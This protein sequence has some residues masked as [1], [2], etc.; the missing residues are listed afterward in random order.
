M[1]LN[2]ID[3]TGIHIGSV[4]DFLAQLLGGGDGYPGFLQIYGADINVQPNSPDGQMLN[5]F[6]QAEA[7]ISELAVQ[8]Y[9]SFDPDQAYGASLDR[10][11]AYNGVIR[12]GGTFTQ[13]AVAVTTS[14][15]LTLPGLDTNPA[16]G[17]FTVQD[18]A[19]NQYSLLTTFAF[20]GA[21][22]IDL[23]F[24]AVKMG[25]VTSAS[26]TVTVIT[27]PQLG[28][29]SVN[30]PAP[31]TTVGT[32]QE[33]DSAL[34]IRRSNSV[35]NPSQGFD[36]GLR[37]GLLDIVGVTF[38]KVYQNR[39]DT[40]D[41]NGIP[42]HLIWVVVAA[43]SGD[44][45]AI[46]Q[47]IYVHLNAGPG[48]KNAGTGGAGTVTLSG[49]TIGSIAVAAGGTGYNNAPTVKIVGNGTGAT[50]H[51]VVTAGVI[52]SF[53]VDTPGTGYTGT[54]TVVLNPNTNLVEILQLDGNNDPIYF[55]N[56][57]LQPLW[58]EATVVAITGSVD[59][60]FISAQVLEEF[61]SKYDIGQAADTASIVAFIKAIAPNASVSAEGVSTDGSS[62]SSLVTPTGVNYQ[63]EIP[64]S[65]HISIT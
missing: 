4:D 31:P 15:A 35:A 13:L 25:P 36:Q 44:N 63:F 19:G 18:G 39:G 23:I 16:G 55:D 12:Q 54:P 58:F 14:Q 10:D 57:I 33:T 45:A 27:T 60:A 40:T 34:R 50:A 65:G 42:P 51:A 3:A 21:A 9:D 5:I 41:A 22:T 1:P 29:T 56:P 47:V 59:L 53:V 2:Y 43:P 17:A 32:N 20:I 37:G 26:N 38:A 62:Y 6:A 8:V 11:C 30:N 61:G 7:D 49:S 48:F 64:D 46:A 52:T 28:V 24:Q